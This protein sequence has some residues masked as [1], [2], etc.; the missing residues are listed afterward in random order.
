VD[1]CEYGNEPSGF[2]EW[3]GNSSVEEQL[4]A[5]Q[6][7]LSSMYIY[8]YVRIHIHVFLKHLLLSLM[9]LK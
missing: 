6:E 4:L 1:F 8:I 3:R 2:V 9:H 7:G 5:Y